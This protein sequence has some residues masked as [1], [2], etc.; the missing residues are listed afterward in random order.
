M[1]S[2]LF[3]QLLLAE[4]HGYIYICRRLAEIKCAVISLPGN[5]VRH[6]FPIHSKNF[7]FAAVQADDFQLAGMPLIDDIGAAQTV[8]HTQ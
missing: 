4:G 3:W 5:L 7:Q 6:I 1:F 2:L 8:D